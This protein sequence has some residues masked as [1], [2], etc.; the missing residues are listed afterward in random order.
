MKKEKQIKQ[1]SEER[2]LQEENRDTTTVLNKLPPKSIQDHVQDLEIK[3]LKLNSEN[4]KLRLLRRKSKQSFQKYSTLFN[5]APAAYLKIT[6]QSKIKMLNLTMAEMF[7]TSQTNIKNRHLN[8]LVATESASIY[9]EFIKQVFSTNEI[10]SCDINLIIGDKRRFNAHLNGIS[11]TDKN[12][13]G[14]ITIWD[15]S[16]HL[17]A[18]EELRLA[19]EKAEENDQLKSAFLANMSHEIRTPMN[20]ILGFTALLKE[21]KLNSKEQ[22]EYLELIEKSGN[23]MLN[24]IN[25]I[26]T[27]SKVEA[28]QMLI[29]KSTFNLNE[30]IQYLCTFYKMPTQQKGLQ[31]SCK[32]PPEIKI[33]IHSDKEKVISI[34]TNLINNAI[35]YTEKGIIE[36]GYRQRSSDEIE[37]FVSDTGIGIPR[38]KQEVIFERFIQAEMD[39][40]RAYE[41]AGLGLAISKAFTQMLGGK[42]WVE[43]DEGIGS[44]FYFTIPYTLKSHH[45]TIEENTAKRSE[46]ITT[47][48]SLKILLAEDD[49]ISIILFK[50]SLQPISKNILTARNGLEALETCRKNPD[51]DL[52]LMDI[53]MPEMSGYEATREIRKFNPKVFIIAQTAYALLGEKEKA[54]NAGCNDYITKP[55]DKELLFKVIRN[56]FNN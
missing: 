36:F 8:E 51:I 20:G 43:S 33:T 1:K 6:S 31:L 35:K 41:G 2:I 53:K 38:N 26:I 5:H 39:N 25:D 4:Q 28:G 13:E 18:E 29:S 15:N 56:K 50:R 37:F 3:N 22:K 49:E 46:P 11:N 30:I 47:P 42:I 24:I 45:H 54:L 32:I 34:L 7:H 52:I 21:P 14:L 48:R 44:T 12:Q 19:K 17:K 10:Q 16:A 9:H 23:R 55:I 40:K 27:I